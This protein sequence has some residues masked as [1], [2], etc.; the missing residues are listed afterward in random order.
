M[1]GQVDTDAEFHTAKYPK[2]A[3]R[4]KGKTGFTGLA[5]CGLYAKY[6]KREEALVLG[7]QEWIL[8]PQNLWCELQTRR[9]ETVISNRRVLVKWARVACR[10]AS[11]TVKDRT[12]VLWRPMEVHG[13]RRLRARRHR[14]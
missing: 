10:M 9:C 6:A 11:I 5:G 2:Y 3:K 8:G 13:L 14:G 7:N 4:E 12:R 1:S